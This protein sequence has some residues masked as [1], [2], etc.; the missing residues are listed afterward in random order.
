MA[1]AEAAATSVL[2]SL[3]IVPRLQ[4]VGGSLATTKCELWHNGDLLDV[5]Y[6]KGSPDASRVGAL[7][8]ALEHHFYRFPNLDV[9]VVTYCRGSELLAG[10]EATGYPQRLFETLGDGP[11]PCITYSLLSG[12]RKE[13][14]PLALMNPPYL[15]DILVDSSVNAFDQADYRYLGKYSSNNGVAA[16]SG[17][18][19][20]LLHGLL[21]AVERDTISGFL[22]QLFVR[23]DARGAAVFSTNEAEQLLGED[24]YEAARLA[25]LRP[26]LVMLPNRFEIPTV[27]AVFWDDDGDVRMRGFG[28]S[29]SLEHAARRALSELIQTFH[30]CRHFHPK[31]AL[32]KDRQT[33]S[34]AAG[35]K[36]YTD[37][38]TFDILSTLCA[39]GS[40]PPRALTD[41]G[42]W[43][44]QTVPEQLSE[45]ERRLNSARAKACY[46]LLRTL[47]GG[48]VVCHARLSPSDHFF[49]S[50]DGAMVLPSAVEV[51]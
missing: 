40:A 30:I 29:L 45:L 34:N 22:Y 12:G 14:F 51:S 8:E 42:D 31:Q 6:G 44:E 5:G 47:P 36:V 49:L 9:G 20:T 28:C 37:C 1:Q 39:V 11:V 23:R 16:G 50:M 38:I 33:M 48:L 27:C 2:D 3:A 15:D 4:T 32:E 19:E 13:R 21:E 41:D 10:Q 17:V 26:S 43:L 25:G 7:Y 18:E 24:F 46:A 35:R